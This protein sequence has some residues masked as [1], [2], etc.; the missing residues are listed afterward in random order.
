M[1]NSLLRCEAHAFLTPHSSLPPGC[2]TS[3]G[4]SSPA[5]I[6][7]RRSLLPFV[8]IPYISPDGCVSPQVEYLR[9]HMNEEVAALSHHVMLRDSVIAT[10]RRWLRRGQQLAADRMAKHRH[11]RILIAWR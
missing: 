7:R 10:L 5:R 3:D 9:V 8:I 4:A 1:I 11:R 6:S 2:V